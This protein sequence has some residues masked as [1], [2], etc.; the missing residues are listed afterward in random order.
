MGDDGVHRRSL[1]RPASQQ[2]GGHRLT[3]GLVGA[4]E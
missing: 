3:Q 1:A 4:T 2:V